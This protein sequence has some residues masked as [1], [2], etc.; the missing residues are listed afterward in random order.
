MDYANVIHVQYSLSLLTMVDI[1]DYQPAMARVARSRAQVVSSFF[2]IP[3]LTSKTFFLHNVKTLSSW[4]SHQRTPSSDSEGPV[5]LYQERIVTFRGLGTEPAQKGLGSKATKAK[6]D[7]LSTV[8]LP[9]V[10]PRQPRTSQ[11]Q[12]I[13]NPK[14]E[15]ENSPTLT[16]RLSVFWTQEVAFQKR[17]PSVTSLS[18]VETLTPATMLSSSVS[19]LRNLRANRR[20]AL[21]S[22]DII[23][24]PWP[25]PQTPFTSTP[26]IRPLEHKLRARNELPEPPPPLNPLTLDD[27]SELSERDVTS[28]GDW[29]TVEDALSDQTQIADEDWT[30]DPDLMLWQDY[31]ARTEQINAEQEIPN[32]EEVPSQEDKLQLEIACRHEF[33]ATAAGRDRRTTPDWRAYIKSYSRVRPYNLNLAC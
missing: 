4:T 27:L 10:E 15:L 1:L 5:P 29:E 22:G 24:S 30:T 17:P 8:P 7:L 18:S 11:I 32:E 6:P 33:I 20:P 9:R 2:E 13:T 16:P 31:T 23:G 21:A 12:P 26:Y 25:D 19:K 28:E 3:R 14:L